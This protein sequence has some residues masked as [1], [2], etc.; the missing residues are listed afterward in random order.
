MRPS[1]MKASA[2]IMEVIGYDNVQS[3]RA[4][5]AKKRCINIENTSNL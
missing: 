2:R 4:E 5:N 1:G 3:I